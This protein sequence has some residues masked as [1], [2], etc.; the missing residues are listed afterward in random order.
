MIPSMNI[1]ENESISEDSGVLFAEVPTT[2][3]AMQRSQAEHAAF[4]RNLYSNHVDAPS[5]LQ[6]GIYC[7]FG[8]DAL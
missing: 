1:S 6:L 4:R 7:T 3:S 8:K 2:T 5:L